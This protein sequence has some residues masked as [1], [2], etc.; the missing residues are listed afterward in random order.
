MKAV[1]EALERE[2][3]GKYKTT[4]ASASG[5]DPRDGI[6]ISAW[7]CFQMGKRCS[8]LFPTA[9][10]PENSLDN[11]SR[12]LA[13]P[14]P[15]ERHVR[16]D[17]HQQAEGEEVREGIVLMFDDPDDWRK[18]R[19]SKRAS[20][21]TCK[22]CGGG[23]SHSKSVASKRRKPPVTVVQPE[24][25]TA[26]KQSREAEFLLGL[27][28]ARSA[29]GKDLVKKERLGRSG[30]L[31]IIC[32]FHASSRDGSRCASTPRGCRAART[33]CVCKRA[34]AWRLRRWS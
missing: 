25:R 13:R 17:A 16:T 12:V 24:E 33:S 30:S 8:R 28:P 9:T 23:R 32:D 26:L 19:S 22:R 34:S 10:L 1:E 3:E 4:D 31:M 2:E 5:G 21:S 29:D 14:R 20:E 7:S 18:W 11:E 27:A 6:F 15:A